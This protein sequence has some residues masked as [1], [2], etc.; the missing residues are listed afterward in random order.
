RHIPLALTRAVLTKQAPE[1]LATRLG[2]LEA[3]TWTL[4][5]EGV[6]TVYRVEAALPHRLVAWEDNRGEKAEII[7]SIRD[8]YW[9]HNHNLNDG[10]RKKLGLSYGVDGKR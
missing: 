3:F 7:A 6:K 4:E 5:R 1:K 2:A 8:T 9:V 10:L